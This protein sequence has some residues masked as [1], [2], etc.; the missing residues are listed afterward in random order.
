[1]AD[2]P[3][4]ARII[5]GL[6]RLHCGYFRRL[7]FLLAGLLVVPHLSLW[8]FPTQVKELS[9]RPGHGAVGFSASRKKGHVSLRDIDSDLM[10]NI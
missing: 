9:L 6:E 4:G 1:M 10:G 8:A 5:P 3:R 7:T 2:L